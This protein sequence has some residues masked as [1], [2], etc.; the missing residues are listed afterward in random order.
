M[1]PALA[2]QLLRGALVANGWRLA[3]TVA[4]IALGVAL[5]AAVHTIHAS[6]LAEIDRAARALSGTADLEVRGP[7]SGF[8]DAVFLAI[9][10]RPEVSAASPVVEIEAAMDGHDATLRVLGIDAFRAIRLQPAF[11]ASAGSTGLGRTG[12]LLDPQAMW[13][14]PA[15]A[16]RLGLREGDAIRLR[17]GSGIRAYRMAGTLPGLGGAGDVGVVDIA[18]AQADFARVGRLSRIDVRLRPGV[19]AARF[20]REAAALLP[21]GVTLADAASVS[22]RAAAVTRA[23]RVNL[24]ALALVALATGA[25]LVFSTLSLQAARRRQEFALLRALG[26]TRRG[27]AALL[28]LE[29][30][31]LGLLGAALGTALGLGGSRALLA[32]SGP[33]L[34]AGYFGGHGGAFAPD[35][36]GLAGIALVAIAMSVA[37]ALRVARAVNRIDVSEA[38][39]DRTIDLPQA[40]G[41]ARLALLWALAGLPFLLL[42]PLGGLPLGGYAA[43]ACW[44]AAAV[45]MVAPLCRALVARS[46]P[47]SPTA[48]LALAQVRDLPGHLAA[49]VAGIV[50]SASLC[51]AMAIMVHSF[52]VSVEAWLH[53]VVRGDLYVTGAEGG[54]ATFFTREE[55]ER[56]AAIAGVSALETLRYDRLVIADAPSPLTLVARPIDARILGGFQA[57]PAGMPARG[58]E[59]PVWISEAARDLHRWSTGDAVELP[60]AG[61]RV[62]VRIAGVVR[63]YARTWGAVLMDTA[64]Y[65]RLTGDTA[66]NDLVL[67]L[68]APLDARAAQ[69]AV[70]AALPE[71]RGLQFEDAA[72]L[73]TRSLAIFDRSF[74]V[75]YALEAIAIVIGLAGVTSSFASLAWSRRRE[76]GVLRFLGLTRRDIL[77]MLALEGAA[78]GAL[79]A[80]IGLASGAAISLVLVHVVNRQSFHWGMEVHWPWAAL[81]ALCAAIVATCALGARASG[82]FAVRHEAVLAVKDDA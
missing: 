12:A 47:G 31:A 8:D 63:D 19:D 25:F 42:P 64:D 29:G 72:G 10:Q 41:H 46:R 71:A 15:M 24:D 61:R 76:F 58:A 53:G 51:V 4:C 67:H 70:R 54:H 79:G 77:G 28:A 30:A 23:Y 11:V 38:L 74:A 27:V 35:A 52:R 55:Q 36:A 17:V 69:A 43:I 40:A 5:G 22:G 21:P 3:L 1:T 14:A 26:A 60:I 2:L 44:L 37:G 33:D 18:A 6:A 62:R 48:Q 20:R 39:R 32:R 73:R 68:A 65:R 49:S 80:A 81:A 78:A 9:A 45:A 82:A 13:L 66:A 50:V 57:E 34:G 16:A 7:R 75:T 56:I 59:I